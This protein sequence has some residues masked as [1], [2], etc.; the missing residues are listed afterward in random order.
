MKREINK[1]NI[2]FIKEIKKYI[3]LPHFHNS[4]EKD[5]FLENNPPLLREEKIILTRQRINKN[6]I[7]L[8]I[9]GVN[10]LK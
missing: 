7:G 5:K 6:K 8:F 4:I 2:P 1:R 3:L 9:L 10:S